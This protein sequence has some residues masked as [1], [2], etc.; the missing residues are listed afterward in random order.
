MF[1]KIVTL[2]YPG[3][4]RYYLVWWLYINTKP[5]KAQK[6]QNFYSTRRAGERTAQHAKNNL[7]HTPHFFI[8]LTGKKCSVN[9]KTDL[10]NY[11]LLYAKINNKPCYAIQEKP[12]RAL[13]I[14][15]M[16]FIPFF[17]PVADSLK[18]ASQAFTG[19][20]KQDRKDRKKQRRKS[21]FVALLNPRFAAK[22][23]QI[24]KSP[25]YTLLTLH[26]PLLY[27][28]PFR[29]YM[30]TK[31]NRKR[32]VKVILDTYRFIN[33][34]S[35]ALKQVITQKSGVEILRFNLNDNT[36][37]L[38][39]LGYDDCYRKEGELVF[40][41]VC[42]EL[43]GRIVSIAFSFE[44]LEP[45]CWVCRIGC[46]Q[47]H[48][49]KDSN[50]SK[51][52]QKMLHGLRPKAFI[53]FVVQEFCRQLGFTAVYGAGDTIQAYRKKHIIHLHWLHA[54]QFDYNS[55][56]AECS[57]LPQADGWYLLPVKPVR[58]CAE[59]IKT[60]KRA[61][62]KRRYSMLDELSDK[63]AVAVKGINE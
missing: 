28:K 62:Y 8:K 13:T 37:G 10:C 43:G 56:W 4:V 20:Q 29:V 31:W 54:I 44:E 58:K 1:F 18:F 26:R 16:A 53:T 35:G 14:I 38:L 21:F 52:A 19:K 33:E 9:I 51:A 2:L 25:D 59:D 5:I 15:K 39:M 63:I 6:P 47:G 22:W 41:F 60:H 45:G 36:K 61:L 30:S 40:S 34:K 12:V 49:K 24:L 48:A 32:R 42:E 17:S 3:I 50:P 11:K 46:I 7:T 57:G 55:I 27:F 23:F